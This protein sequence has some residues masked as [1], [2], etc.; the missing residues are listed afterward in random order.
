MPVACGSRPL[1]TLTFI[2]EGNDAF[3]VD[4]LWIAATVTDL[5]LALRSCL[6]VSGCV[7]PSVLLMFKSY[8]NADTP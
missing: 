3:V 1:R 4:V 2:H 7:S 5:R 6:H 8:S